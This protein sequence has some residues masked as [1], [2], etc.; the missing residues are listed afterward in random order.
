[1]SKTRTRI[2]K[3][4]IDSREKA[5]ACLGEIVTLTIEQR[6][7]QNALDGEI[8]AARERHEEPLALLATQIEHRQ[9]L[10]RVW[11]EANPEEFPA[12]RKSVEMT[13]G[14]IGF[15]L[16]TPKLKALLRK[17]WEAILETVKAFGLTQYVRTKEEVNREA[18]IADYQQHEIGED[19][20]RKIG[21]AVVQE[22]AFF[23]QVNLTEQPTREAVA[24]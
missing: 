15:R 8:T 3:P 14:T 16:G 1:M 12:G 22:E 18:I 24:S 10:L 21:V 13:H 11:A 6:R 4:L 9:E 5:E 20:L 17:K 23:V 2:V 19:T 7:I